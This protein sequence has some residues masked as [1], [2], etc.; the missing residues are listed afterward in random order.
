MSGLEA[1]R[2]VGSVRNHR[3][4]ILIVLVGLGAL[5]CAADAALLGLRLTWE[6]A[7][8]ATGGG[9][10]GHVSLA[11]FGEHVAAVGARDASG[12][13]VSVSL[14]GAVI[15]PDVQLRPGTKVHVTATVQRSRWL[16]WLLGRTERVEA[17]TR[18]PAAFLKSTMVYPDVGRPVTVRFSSPV[19]I[20]SV[21]HP[22]GTYRTVTLR[23]ASRIVPI[24]VSADAAHLAGTALVSGAPRSWERLPA[25]VRISWFPSGPTAHVL[26]RPALDGPLPPSAP[27]ILTFSRPLADVLGGA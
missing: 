9:G 8:I 20:I 24:G 6:P 21:R 16:G 3:N 26:V 4:R 5:F 1:S 22:D 18:T 12:R 2:G 11:R 7:R 27:I 17:V 23:R 19:R 25:P 14:T 13:A 10:L 15:S